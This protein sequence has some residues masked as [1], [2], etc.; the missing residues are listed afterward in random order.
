LGR[1]HGVRRLPDGGLRVR[2]SV[3]E[4]DALRALSGQI[5]EV[6]SGEHDLAGEGSAI[7]A[8]LF[9]SAYTQDPLADL[10]YQEMVGNSI[11]DQRS[12][13]LETFARTLDEGLTRRV[14]WTVDLNP[15]EA[16][17][18]LSA[19]NDARLTLAMV[20][21][22][23]TEAQWEEGPDPRDQASVMLYYLGWLEEQLVTAMMA[24]LPDDGH[25]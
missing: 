23:E 19:V 9:P 2:L 25:S 15:D 11:A 10:E 5:A 18:W 16:A 12:E 8:R 22:I 17:A 13:S 3:R 4:R 6:V 21:G 7:R 14:F 24:S 20:V 1:L